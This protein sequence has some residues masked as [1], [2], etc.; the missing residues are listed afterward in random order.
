MLILERIKMNKLTIYDIKYAT[1]GKSPYFF[2]RN[3]MKAFGQTMKSFKV[4]VSPAGR[5][6]IYAPMRDN[7]RSSCLYNRLM[8]YTFREFQEGDLITVRNDDGSMLNHDTLNDI[9][10]FISQH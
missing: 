2:S 4:A 8:G 5:I 3:T 6:F 7:Y 1:E 9:K 10:N